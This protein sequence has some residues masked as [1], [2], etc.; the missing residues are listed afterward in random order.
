MIDEKFNEKLSVNVPLRYDSVG[1]LI[2]N[3]PIIC[4]GHRDLFNIVKDCHVV[5]Q[6]EIKLDML[7]L[8]AEA[9]IVKTPA[10]FSV[11]VT[12]DPA[13]ILPDVKPPVPS[14]TCI[15]PTEPDDS[16]TLTAVIQINST[17]K[18]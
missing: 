1:C 4:G 6:P 17:T 7:E 14:D 18:T 16:I 11:T 3:Y 10:P 8:R 9:A 5:G 13:L 2:Q 15:A 12:L